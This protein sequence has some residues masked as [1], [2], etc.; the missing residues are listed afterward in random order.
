MSYPIGCPCPDPAPSIPPALPF[1]LGMSTQPHILF[2]ISL[3]KLPILV[4]PSFCVCLI[5]R[6]FGQGT[7]REHSFNTK[8]AKISLFQSLWSSGG[9]FLSSFTLQVREEAHLSFA[10]FPVCSSPSSFLR[11][12][13]D[14]PRAALPLTGPALY[15]FVVRC[16]FLLY[17]GVF[18]ASEGRSHL[19]VEKSVHAVNYVCQSC[20][21]LNSP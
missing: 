3:W 12:S 9:A 17:S 11:S 16:E 19:F 21:Y 18:W 6:S 8:P 1:L 2:S 13:L 5:L 4:T 20:T 10:I 15:F 14:A 7:F